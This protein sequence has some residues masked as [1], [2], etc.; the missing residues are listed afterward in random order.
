MKRVDFP[1][2]TSDFCVVIDPRGYYEFREVVTLDTGYRLE[3]ELG[4]SLTEARIRSEYPAF[5][6]QYH[7]SLKGDEKG[8]GFLQV[9]QSKWKNVG[10]LVLDGNGDFTV[11]SDPIVNTS[12]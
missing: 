8:E 7:L 3:V 4:K 5:Q 2:P 10:N 11:T 12:K 6:I 9:L 1:A